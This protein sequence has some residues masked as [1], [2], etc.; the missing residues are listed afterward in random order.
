MSYQSLRLSDV[1][2]RKEYQC[3]WCGERIEKGVKHRSRAGIFEGEF[4][5]N[6]EHLECAMA[7]SRYDWRE[8]DYGY[9]THSH[10]RGTTDHQ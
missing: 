4:Q 1:V 8:N 5:A 2:A 7:M 9:E 6:R 10:K 3:S